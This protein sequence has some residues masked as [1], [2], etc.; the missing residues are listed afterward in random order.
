MRATLLFLALTFPSLLLAAPSKT[1]RC[2]TTHYPPFTIYDEKADT[3][4][5]LD[6]DYI[7][8][9]EKNLNLKIDVVHLPWA[10]VK[11]E[12]KLGYYDCYFSLA[13]YKERT[14]YLDFTSEPLHTTKYGLFTLNEDNLLTDDLSKAAIAM[15]RGVILPEII[16][17]KYTIN[18][19]NLLRSLST[20]A[21]FE[22]LEKNRVQYAITNYQAGL[23][24]S[25]KYKNIY[26]RQL[27]DYSF[28]VYIAFKRGVMD[29][30]LVDEQIK[31]F[32]TQK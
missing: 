26:A 24:Y 21:T 13:N 8:F 14:E 2:V 31:Q 7:K 30:K 17:T 9:I 10:R 4:T 15:L 32:K 11:K 29:T 1:L 27:N 28:P 22:L 23:W 20:E 16:A 19:N 6:I 18:E 3:F 12:M 5:G 25:K